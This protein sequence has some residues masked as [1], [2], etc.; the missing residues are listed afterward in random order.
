M[1]RTDSRR[2]AGFTLIELLVVIAII[3]ILIGLLLP[4]VQKVRA[5]ASRARC[6]SNL[7]QIGIAAHNFHD[8]YNAFP[9]SSGKIGGNAYTNPF[10]ALLP[11]AE[12]TPLY[13]RLVKQAAIAGNYGWSD[14]PLG[15]GY[16]PMP[17]MD[18]SLDATVVAIYVCPSE[19]YPSV[20]EELTKWP[21]YQVSVMSYRA[22]GGAVYSPG[23]QNNKGI[24]GSEACRITDVHDGSSNTIM[25]G[26]S[27]CSDPAW[28]EY[29]SSGMGY[30]PGYPAPFVTGGTWLAT[31]FYDFPPI[32]YAEVGTYAFASKLPLP[33]DQSTMYAWM[34]SFRGG[35]HGPGGNFV[36]ADGS[37]RFISTEINSSPALLQSST[38]EMITP[39]GALTT[40]SAGEIV[41]P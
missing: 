7:K 10:V 28:Q 30:P 5:A 16:I 29:S 37:V 2:P 23:G 25:F 32:A 15:M 39:F 13:D 41:N 40:R 1:F 20:L 34:Q 18:K 17:D 19:P 31:G 21:E 33:P 9:G 4:A 12:Q 26:E 36:L 38:G 6:Q 3:A 24:F 14:Y 8:T 22:S 27:T 35:N 11:Y